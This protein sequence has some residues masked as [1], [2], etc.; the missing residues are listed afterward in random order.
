[1]R[2]RAFGV[3]CAEAINKKC[4]HSASTFKPE[5]RR[6]M[7]SF[8]QHSRS[9]FG[10][11]AMALR[12]VPFGLPKNYYTLSSRTKKIKELKAPILHLLLGTF[13]QWVFQ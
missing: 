13:L 12:V 6:L 8:S 9:F 7:H 11:G 4:L 10:G 1:M 3:A 2:V 5:E